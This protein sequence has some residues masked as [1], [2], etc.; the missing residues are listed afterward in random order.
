MDGI[1]ALVLIGWLIR[2]ASSQKKR[3]Q[4]KG[5]AA[6]P[7]AVHFPKEPKFTD[8]KPVFPAFF[9]QESAPA[10]GEGYA[11]DW[12]GSLSA[13]SAEGEDLCDPSLGHE[14]EIA[15]DPRSVYAG[16]IGRES[17]VDTSP[18]GLIQGVVMSEILTRPTYPKYR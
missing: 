7:R 14:R 18:R 11:P 12:S 15:A 16:E 17:L 10:E 8:A 6:K 9:Q 2:F 5:T 3:K 1:L 13:D 4:G